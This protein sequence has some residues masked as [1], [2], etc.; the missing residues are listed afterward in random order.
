[1]AEIGLDISGQ[2]PKPLRQ[3]LGQKF[4]YV[5]TVCDSAAETCPFFPGRAERRHRDFTDPPAAPPES[6][7]QWAVRC[8]PR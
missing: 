3:F 2:R 6:V 4:D 8:V 7:R 1:M 5:L